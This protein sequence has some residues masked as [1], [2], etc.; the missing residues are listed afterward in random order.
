MGR[1]RLKEAALLQETHVALP[2]VFV[3]CSCVQLHRHQRR[4]AGCPG[5]APRVAA[6]LCNT[7]VR[8]GAARTPVLLREAHRE[9]G[10]GPRGCPAI[11]LEACA[12]AANRPSPP[13]L[14]PAVLDLQRQREPGQRRGGGVA[15]VSLLLCCLL[16]TCQEH[17]RA[18]GILG[19]CAGHTARLQP[20]T[21]YPAAKPMSCPE[22]PH[23]IHPLNRCEEFRYTGR[24]RMSSC[25]AEAAYPW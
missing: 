13:P 17:G 24:Q 2:C 3:P 21:Q 22:P 9:P 18:G 12:C 8:G 4:P 20:P 25:T 10:Q 6:L 7:G 19:L 15:A 5:A 14:R 1:G 11:T 23:P 16:A